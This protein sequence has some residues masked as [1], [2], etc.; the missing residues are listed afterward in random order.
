MVH[1]FFSYPC[2]DFARKMF[3][4]FFSTETKLAE[5][6]TTNSKS[7]DGITEGV[8]INTTLLD[9]LALDFCCLTNCQKLWYNCSLFLNTFFDAN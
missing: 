5:N 7:L 1:R 6:R 9:I 2:P 8:Q 3:T 4:F